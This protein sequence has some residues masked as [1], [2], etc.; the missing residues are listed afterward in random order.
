MFV[1]YLVTFL[2]KNWYRIKYGVM[3]RDVQ[4]GT[5]YY[6]LKLGMSRKRKLESDRSQMNFEE[7][8]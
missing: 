4:Y 5:K 1:R 7:E 6:R 2:N 3:Y 8:E